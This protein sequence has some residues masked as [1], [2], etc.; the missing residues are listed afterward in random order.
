MQ[1]SFSFKG[2]TL[3]S[4]NLLVADGECMEVVNLRYRDGVLLPI[5]IAGQDTEL[6]SVYS[7]IY[8][9]SASEMYLAI[10]NSDELPVHFYDK[11]LKIVTS[12][13]S[14]DELMLFPLLKGV[15]RIEFSGNIVCCI[16]VSTIYYLIYDADKY[17]WL[18]ERPPMPSLTFSVESIVYSLKTDSSYLLMPALDNIDDPLYWGNASLGFFDECLAE[19]HS[20]GYFVDR[21]LFR[22]AF[23][24]YDGSYL[25]Y[26]PIY[27]V[28]DDNS[29]AGLARDADNYAAEAIDAGN[30]NAPSS[31]RYRVKVQGFKPL[32]HF[33]NIDL[34][35]WENIIVAIDLFTS[36]SI[37]GH[38][39]AETADKWSIRNGMYYSNERGNKRYVNKDNSELLSDVTNAAMFYK[40]AEY[41]IDGVLVDSVKNVTATG[42]ALCD[43]MPDEDSPA[44]ARTAASSY[45]FNGRLHLGGMRE[46]LFK[47]YNSN[48]YLP[49]A[50][51]AALTTYAMVHTKIKTSMGMSV[52]KREYDGTFA[53]GVK[54]GAYYITPYIMYPDSRACETTFVI[55][56]GSTVYRKTFPLTPHKTLNLAAYV[57]SYGDGCTVTLVSGMSDGQQPILLSAENVKA[58]F[59]YTPGEYVIQY[60][61]GKGWY[62]G[63]VEFTARGSAQYRPLI[64]TLNPVD[65]DTITIV[66]KQGDVLDNLLDIRDIS[67]DSSWEV[68]P[69][70]PQVD[71][72][73][74]CEVRG[75]VMKVSAVDNPFYFPAKNTYTPSHEDIQ[76]VCSNT[77]A[78]SQG[79]FG[80]HPLYVFCKDGIWAM[81]VDASGNVT[82]AAAYPLSREVCI[83]PASLCCIDSGVVFVSD[84]GVMLLQGGELTC[85]SAS[86]DS[87]EMPIKEI[88]PSSIFYK[89]AALSYNTSAVG[90]ILFKEYIK[91]VVIGFLASEKEIWISNP[92]YEYTYVFSLEN[93]CWAKVN[94]GYTCFVNCYPHLVT[95]TCVDDKSYIS[96]LQNNN[97]AGYAPVLLITRPQLWGTKLPKRIIQ[98]M[99]HASV[100][101]TTQSASYEYAGLGC[102]LLCSNDGVHFKLLCGVEKEKDFNDVVFPFFPTQSYKYY[103]IALSGAI[104][105]DSRV[106][107]AELSIECV[108]NN[109]LR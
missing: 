86:L 23:R 58:F 43:N 44:V 27:Y 90:R 91:D 42:L 25:C 38:K 61:G 16:A 34:K 65:G 59:S 88:T 21:A 2:L 56:I 96:L 11:N 4:D 51:E 105:A 79:Q 32:F 109:R 5:P 82:Y 106:V 9:H 6:E 19:L 22:F 30:G 64:S 17:R 20:K 45:L 1:K 97:S 66:I 73:N 98:L 60:I 55:K 75:N 48:D 49:A 70:I 78:L 67:I 68:L 50:M 31:S 47:G 28:D 104:A 35:A 63:D 77:V 87:N 41:N 12:A 84:K 94:R 54:D 26:S 83:N 39:V 89:I 18:G 7:R 71:E 37:Y 57:H 53:L 103:V 36:G 8:W 72:V 10:E 13:S 107:G 69:E 99:L 95:N 3:G 92:R 29:I 80:Q 102:Y 93:G 24:L 108:W 40:I 74:P 76:A 46:Q 33:K 101:M 14:P 15:E 81:A 62:Y 100:K 85:L 52:V